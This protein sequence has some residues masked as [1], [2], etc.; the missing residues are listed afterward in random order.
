MRK[1]CA[2]IFDQGLLDE[3]DGVFFWVHDHRLTQM[4]RSEMLSGLG[5]VGPIQTMIRPSPMTE[6]SKVM[7]RDV[8]NYVYIFIY[9]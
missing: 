7:M 4:L 8:W 9:E 6:P 5:G 2:F 1:A 3:K